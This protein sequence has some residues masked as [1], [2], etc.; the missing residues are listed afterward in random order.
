[1]KAQGRREKSQLYSQGRSAWRRADEAVRSQQ[2]AAD[3]E[4]LALLRTEPRDL[5]AGYVQWTILPS[6]QVAANVY[7]LCPR[8]TVL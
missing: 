1:M 3:P 5:G 4:V 2:D 8:V 6:G 7:S